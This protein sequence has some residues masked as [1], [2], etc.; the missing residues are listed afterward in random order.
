MFIKHKYSIFDGYN[1]EYARLSIG[2]E[3]N[4]EKLY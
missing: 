4:S 3:T 1:P 2:K